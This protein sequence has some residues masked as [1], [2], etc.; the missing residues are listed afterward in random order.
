MPQPLQLL[1]QPPQLGDTST[2]APQPHEGADTGPQP[3][4]E[5]TPGGSAPQPQPETTT[6]PGAQAIGTAA[7]GA[8]KVGVCCTVM[9]QPDAFSQRKARTRE[10]GSGE[11]DAEQATTPAKIATSVQCGKE[12]PTLQPQE[13]VETSQLAP[14]QSAFE[15]HGG[16]SG[17][18]PFTPQN[19]A[20]AAPV[21]QPIP[22]GQSAFT[23]QLPQAWVRLEQ[24][25]SRGGHCV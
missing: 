11:G 25:A 8:K 10:V 4:L 13:P 22:G 18:A 19:G 24:P 9:V 17:P 21:E 1:P 2:L 12:R 14:P 16:Q 15:A 23:A 3:Q 6:T 5:T 20:Q 7:P